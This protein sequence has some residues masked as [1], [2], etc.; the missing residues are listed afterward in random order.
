MRFR[1]RAHDGGP[2]PLEGSG[3][4]EQDGDR[5]TGAPP[6]PAPSLGAGA[7]RMGAAAL[8]GVRLRYEEGGPAPGGPEEAA[9]G[10]GIPSEGRDGPGDPRGGSRAGTGADGS[11]HGPGE[12]RRLGV[13]ALRDIE[14]A[15]RGRGTSG[16]DHR[17]GAG[18]GGEPTGGHLPHAAGGDRPLDAVATAREAALRRARPEERSVALRAEDVRVAETE[19]AEAAAVALLVDLSHSMTTRSLHEAATR[20]ALALHALVRIRR[21]LDRLRLIG[22]GDRAREMS[23]ADLAAHDWSRVPGT[24]LHHALRLAR[25]HLRA[26]RDLR[27]QVLVVTDGEPT[28]HLDEDGGARFSWPP[29]PRTAELTLAELDAALREG[30]EASFFVLADDPR[31]RAFLERLALRRGVRVVGA[32]ADGL[33]PLVVDR[34]LRRPG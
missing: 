15:R 16:G 3:R 27:P 8:H 30:A 6:G 2:D 33:G 34:Y 26:H 29:D 18:P 1:Y 31:L 12:L 13:L 25:T 17:G 19:P 32:D 24:N 9:P 22:F 10:R 23:P 7:E 21:P 14:T 20:T 4:A 28:A 11:D 5:D